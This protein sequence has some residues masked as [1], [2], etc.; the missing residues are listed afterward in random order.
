MPP[1]PWK[2]TLLPRLIMASAVIAALT[3]AL[4]GEEATDPRRDH[5]LAREAQAKNIILPLKTVL[6]VVQRNVAGEIAGIELERELGNWLYEFKIISPS[7]VMMKIH[8][9]ARTG[10]IVSARGK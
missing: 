1:M 8:V 10:S 4:H 9:D 5:D 2:S 6:D 7:G 3:G